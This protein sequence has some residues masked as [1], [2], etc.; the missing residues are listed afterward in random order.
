M[1]YNVGFD[2]FSR[3][4]RDAAKRTWGSWLFVVSLVLGGLA[5]VAGY[6]PVTGASEPA[7]SIAA[8]IIFVSA[9][10]AAA[11][12]WRVMLGKGWIAGSVLLVWWVFEIL[13]KLLGGSLG[14]MWIAIHLAGMV[15]LAIGVR[16]CWR[17]RGRSSELDQDA[18]VATFE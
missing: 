1:A 9:A 15:N 10:V 18:L 11:L 8:A 17:L 6:S 7:D 3:D 14:I 13:T 2:D 4:P 12:A 16:A 5:V